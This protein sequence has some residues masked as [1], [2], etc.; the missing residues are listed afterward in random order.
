MEKKEKTMDRSRL[1]GEQQSRAVH[2]QPDKTPP[3]RAGACQKSF[4]IV[5][6]LYEGE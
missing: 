2:Y 4:F 1:V 3:P 5:Q 6:S